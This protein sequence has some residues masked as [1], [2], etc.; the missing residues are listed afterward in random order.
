MLRTLVK[1]DASHAKHASRMCWYVPPMAKKRVPPARMLAENLKKL[2]AE[3]GWSNRT[4]AAKSGVSDR[5]IGMLLKGESQATVDVAEALA[6]AFGL[7]GW[8]LIMSNLDISAA[9]KGNLA[10]V[11]EKYQASE[12]TEREM[13]DLLAKQPADN[14]PDVTEPPPRP[15]S[16]VEAV[17]STV[18]SRATKKRNKDDRDAKK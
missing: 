3:E 6:K 11:I 12:G 10:R 9:R 5:F 13:F 14:D 4:L 16:R 15:P 17:K 18:A 8:Q 7:T 2:I 1:K